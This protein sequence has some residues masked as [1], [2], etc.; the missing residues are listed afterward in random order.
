[1]SDP[2]IDPFTAPAVDEGSW[3]VGI[4]LG[5]AAVVVT[6]GVAALLGALGV[7]GSEA[8]LMAPGLTQLL[9]VLPLLFWSMRQGKKRTVWGLAVTA[10]VVF[11]LN[12]A[13]WGVVLV[14][15]S[16]M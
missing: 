13:C 1:M 6:S 2:M 11:L 3:W 9:V 4:G 15:L 7:S 8:A 5:V 16:D 12:G 14:G 10:G